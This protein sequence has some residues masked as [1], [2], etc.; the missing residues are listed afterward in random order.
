M[1]DFGIHT[2]GIGSLQ[3]STFR[4][5]PPSFLNV[6][7]SVLSDL[8]IFEPSNPIFDSSK[9]PW[10]NNVSFSPKTCLLQSLKRKEDKTSLTQKTTT[11]RQISR[12]VVIANS[13]RE[14][15]VISTMSKPTR[16]DSR[17]YEYRPE[18]LNCEQRQLRWPSTCL[19]RTIASTVNFSREL[20]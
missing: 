15:L 11:L 20:K 10:T 3:V 5:K 1:F 14:L 2:L 16:V 6:T 13:P 8:G 7:I 19:S 12:T 4:P 18:A 17:L 9:L